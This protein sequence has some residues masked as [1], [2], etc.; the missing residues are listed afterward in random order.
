MNPYKLEEQI[1]EMKER[2]KEIQNGAKETEPYELESLY[3]MI[4]LYQSQVNEIWRREEEALYYW[5][6]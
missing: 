6:R 5:N 4:E 2:I 3:D 1:E